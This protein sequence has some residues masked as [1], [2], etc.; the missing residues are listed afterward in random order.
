MPPVRSPRAR[1]PIYF[2]SLRRSAPPFFLSPS[3]RESRDRTLPPTA[4]PTG[5]DSTARGGI[6]DFSRVISARPFSPERT[7]RDFQ[8]SCYRTN[9]TPRHQGRG[10]NLRPLSDQSNRDRSA[11]LVMPV[12][13]RH[14]ENFMAK[15]TR[16]FLQPRNILRFN[17]P[18]FYFFI[19]IILNFLSTYSNFFHNM[20][21]CFSITRV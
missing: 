9:F 8:A 4:L 1:R 2:S 6:A 20:S 17:F 5:R 10:G 16:Q 11:R 15:I 14:G 12:S 18:R 13:D 7:E 21:I 19:Y 3:L